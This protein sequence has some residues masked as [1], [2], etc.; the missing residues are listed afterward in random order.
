ML[1]NLL[2]CVHLKYTAEE[3]VCDSLN[4]WISATLPEPISNRW[5][6]RSLKLN[7]EMD[8]L[9]V[10]HTMECSLGKDPATCYNMSKPDDIMLSAKGHINPDVTHKI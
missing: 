5:E 10:V 2:P 7:N 9:Y 3:H 4:M 1:E 8:K 6:F